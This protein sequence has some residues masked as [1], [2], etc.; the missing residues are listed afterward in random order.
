M[1]QPVKA[2]MP[3]PRPATPKKYR[4][5]MEE[6]HGIKSHDDYRWLG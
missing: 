6:A 2:A 3:L 4:S 1:S 5:W